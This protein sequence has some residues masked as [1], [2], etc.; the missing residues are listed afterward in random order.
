MTLPIPLSETALA[1]KKEQLREAGRKFIDDAAAD[2]TKLAYRK[3]WSHFSDWCASMGYQPLPATPDI[4]AEY[5]TDMAVNGYEPKD[6]KGR[7]IGPRRPY[8]VATLERHLAT[9]NRI[10]QL[11][12]LPFYTKAEPLYS[13]FKGIKNR[14]GRARKKKAAILVQHLR[15]MVALC[16]GDA[17]GVRDRA[18]LLLWWAAAERRSE[19]AATQVEHL[20]FTEEGIALLIPRSKT[21][22]QGEGHTLPIPYGRNPATCPV[23]AVR[24]WLDVSGRASGSLFGIGEKQATRILKKYA[25]LLG[26]DPAKVGGH[27]QRRGWISQA[28]RNKEPLHAIMRHSRHESERVAMDY[29]EEATLF[30]DSPAGRIG[31]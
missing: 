9:I 2:N 28:A 26:A 20:S 13:Q 19:I 22:Q 21:D 18:L 1:A 14:L 31:L 11:R 24:A 4:V 17:Q 8:A 29:I 27:S 7:V 12:G 30:E 10:H 3:D 23:L 5:L 16:P 6:K 15:Q 25:A